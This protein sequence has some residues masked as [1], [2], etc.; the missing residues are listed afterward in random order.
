MKPL[1]AFPSLLRDLLSLRLAGWL[2]DTPL[3]CRSQAM[4]HLAGHLLKRPARRGLVEAQ[5]R[6]GLLLCRHCG[7]QRDRRIGQEL[8][9]QAARSGD[10]RARQALTNAS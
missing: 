9:R 5:R 6:L 3:V 10:P 7:G 4:Q 1:S 2:L 8:L